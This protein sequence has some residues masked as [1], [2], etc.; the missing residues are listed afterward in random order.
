[1]LARKGF[2]GLR[3]LMDRRLS[4]PVTTSSG[5]HRLVA[6]PGRPGQGPDRLPPRRGEHP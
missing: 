4:E 5:L 1:M 3:E 6:H 2:Q